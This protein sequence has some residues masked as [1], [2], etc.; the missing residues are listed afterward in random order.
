MGKWTAALAFFITVMVLVV[1]R[2]AANEAVESDA[3]ASVN[4][5]PERQS[6]SATV[7]EALEAESS[8]LDLD[9]GCAGLPS[10]RPYSTLPLMY[11]PPCRFGEM[12]ARREMAKY[13]ARA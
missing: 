9:L 1:L 7:E 10:W 11:D 4:A 12:V 13:E 2:G 5:A 3:P 6:P 8:A